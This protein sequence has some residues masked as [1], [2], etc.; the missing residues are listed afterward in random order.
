MEKDKIQ[1]EDE[2]KLYMYLLRCAIWNEKPEESTMDKYKAV[3]ANNLIE[4]SKDRAQRLLLQKY[5]KIFADYKGE[6]LADSYNGELFAIIKKYEFYKN[7]RIVLDKAKENGIKLVVFKG[8][9]LADLYPEYVRRYSCDTDFYVEKSQNAQAIAMIE[10]LGYVI[11]EHSNSEVTVFYSEE[12]EHTIELHTCLWEDYEGRQLDI[13]ESFNLTAP[14]SLINITACGMDVTTLGYE[15]HL[16]YQIFH[17]IKHFSLEGI[18]IKYLA[19]ITLYVSKY[20]KEIDMEH[21][22]KCMDQLRYTKFAYSLFVLCVEFL[23]M[24]DTILKYRNISYGD[25][26]TAF[27]QDFLCAGEMY[28]DKTA[29]W[30]IMGMMTPYFTGQ[31]GT[32]NSSF[33]RKLEIIFPKADDLPDELA[34]AKKNKI[35]LPVAWIHKIINYLKKYHQNKS[36]WYSAGEKLDVAEHR[37]KL[38]KDMGLI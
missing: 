30:Q 38:M 36:T 27:F 10:E 2:W 3:S 16:I 15:N 1:I 21:F 35:L 26:M 17:I 6:E 29:S 18:G 8:C 37:L 13:L 32:A 14:D 11:N 33:K 9:V 12:K 4:H 7:I 5:I 34:Y 28:A 20:G 22:W 23:G 25:E 19:D 31:R 24:D